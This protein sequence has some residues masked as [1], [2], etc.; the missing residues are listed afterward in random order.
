MSKFDKTLITGGAGFI[1][2][3]T[4]D[5]FLSN[6]KNVI[7]LDNLSTGK[8]ENLDMN[9]K[10]LKFVLGDITDYTTVLK[11]V[12]KCDSIIHLAALPFVQKTIENP[13]GSLRINLMGFI[14]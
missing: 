1:G 12:E 8:Y 6:K 11:Q 3:H 14:N 10:H 4:A 13:L 5:L 2:S 9:N 7:V